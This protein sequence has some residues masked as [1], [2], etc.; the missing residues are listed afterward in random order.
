MA[1]IVNT[2]SVQDTR[3]C[4][5]QRKSRQDV[6]RFDCQLEMSHYRSRRAL[7][8]ANLRDHQ[9]THMTSAVHIRFLAML[10][11][12]A[13][14]YRQDVLHIEPAHDKIG[15]VA[16]RALDVEA[17][18]DAVSNG[19]FYATTLREVASERPWTI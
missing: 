16:C 6:P 7:Y 13:C 18:R 19:T 10:L 11:G 15:A 5:L 3:C 12:E 2:F 1:S 9:G 17:N 14:R 4:P 8:E